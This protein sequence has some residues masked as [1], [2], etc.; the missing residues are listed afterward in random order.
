MIH[1]GGNGCGVDAERFLEQ[2]RARRRK[3]GLE[4]H[5]DKTRLVEFGRFAAERRTRRGEGKPETFHF[6]CF[7]HI[8]GRSHGTGCLKV[9]RKT[10]DKRMVA[11]LM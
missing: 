10:A 7:T 8:C 3:S 1:K 11:K 5:L 4:L 9:Y 6:L 2:L